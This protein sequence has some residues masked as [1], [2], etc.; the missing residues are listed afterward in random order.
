MIIKNINLKLAF[1]EIVST[2]VKDKSV[3]SLRAT[4]T[5]I[6]SQVYELNKS[7][8]KMLKQ[9]KA[10][11]VDTIRNDKT[12]LDNPFI[13]G[14]N[15]LLLKIS[16]TT[17]RLQTKLVRDVVDVQTYL[18]FIPQD[19][20]ENNFHL[21]GS[22]DKIDRFLIKGEQITLVPKSYQFNK[23]GNYEQK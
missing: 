1:D 6:Y 18:K 22:Y 21:C 12:C 4:Q 9:A 7:C 17:P 16:P 11:I 14:D 20:K 23:G 19:K 13:S 2:K 5:D 15:E 10:Q 3:K 8:E